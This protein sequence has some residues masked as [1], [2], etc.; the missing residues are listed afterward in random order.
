MDLGLAIERSTAGDRSAYAQVVV[1]HTRAVLGLLRRLLGNPED[2]RDVAQDT[3]VRAYRNLHRFD[4]ARPL[5]PWLLRIAR[6]LA[7]NHLKAQER[8]AG[9]RAS[10]AAATEPDRL[11]SETSSPLAAVLQ[12]E[13]R[14]AVDQIL[15]SMRPEFREVLVYRYMERLDYDEIALVMDIPVGTV[16]TWLFRAK[17]QFR[18]H[19]EGREVF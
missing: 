19:A 7:Y 2:A 14:S 16:K 4:P 12:V 11:P 3:F 1:A 17:E 10:Q 9:M 5:K 13:Q 18:K 15:G 6:N 8:Q